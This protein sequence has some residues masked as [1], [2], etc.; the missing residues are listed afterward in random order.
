[1]E[2]LCHSVFIPS[3]GPIRP[4]EE[5]AEVSQR[6]RQRASGVHLEFYSHDRK[7]WMD[8]ISLRNRRAMENPDHFKVALSAY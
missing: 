7:L 2:G 5:M 3:P 8:M 6:G 4:G 1:M